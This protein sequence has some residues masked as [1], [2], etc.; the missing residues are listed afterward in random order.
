MKHETSA[1]FDEEKISLSRLCLME[2]GQQHVN[3]VWV[4]QF[5][6]LT[7]LLVDV[8]AK[9]H[10]INNLIYLE[11]SQPVRKCRFNKLVQIL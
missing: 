8:I 1:V 3:M 2:K 11:D 10:Y 9:L 6:M 4:L 5:P 7:N